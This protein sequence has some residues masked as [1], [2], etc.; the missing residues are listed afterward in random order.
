[1]LLVAVAGCGSQKKGTEK[2]ETILR[3]TALP[4]THR[5]PPR[6][7]LQQSGPRLLRPAAPPSPAPSGK[8]EVLERMGIEVGGGRITIDTKKAKSYFEALERQ[9]SHGVN[10]GVK[11]ARQHAS[12]A[13][14]IGIYVDKDR[15]EIDLNKTKNFLK[16][17]GESMKILGEE[18]DRSLK[19][20]R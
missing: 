8:P 3:G 5:S 9:I 10:R 12:G 15:V 19:A 2:N 20:P 14:D 7:G 11:K 4:G 13:E 16:I 6:T 1:M 18:L 17:W